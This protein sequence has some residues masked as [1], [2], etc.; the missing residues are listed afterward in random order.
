MKDDILLRDNHGHELE[1]FRQK[2]SKLEKQALE[3]KR[4]IKELKEKENKYRKIFEYAND[5]IILHSPE[6]H[7][8]D[9]NPAMYKR[10]GYTKNEMLEMSLKD[11]V[12]SEYAKKIQDRVS[13]LEKEK[14]AIFISEDRRKDGTIMPVEVAAHFVRQKHQNFILSIVRDI[15]ERK[16]AE[17]LIWTTNKEKD[18]ILNELRHRMKKNAQIIS[19]MLS[20]M[21][22]NIDN[23]K[24]SAVFDSCQNRLKIMI[25]IHDKVYQQKNLSQIDFLSLLRNLIAHLIAKYRINLMNI[26][27]KLDSNN[28][29]LNVRQAIPCC[30]IIYELVMNSVKH[31]FPDDR[32]GQIRIVSTQDSSGKYA[33]RV[34]D[35]GIGLPKNFDL[36]KIET[37]GMKT[38]IELVTELKGAL[39]VKKTKKTEFEIVF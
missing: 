34:E 10:L 12:S 35:S 20:M 22:G 16:I 14:T 26:S 18:L 31:A 36:K 5:G 32:R 27:I 37:F 3:H 25:F 38:V 33:L 11:L 30:L 29:F 9:V 19:D 24:M 1:S 13:K 8:F 15:S 28:F 21:A 4:K 17:E 39:R 6:G 23:Q 7:I 2:A